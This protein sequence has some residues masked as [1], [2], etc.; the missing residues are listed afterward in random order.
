MRRFLAENWLWI[1]APVI[2]VAL[3]IGALYLFTDGEGQAPFRY[4][5]F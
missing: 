4:A 3:G 1:L 2:V 5:L